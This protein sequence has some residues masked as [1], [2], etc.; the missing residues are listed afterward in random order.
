MSF[1]SDSSFH[2]WR[3]RVVAIALSLAGCAPPYDTLLVP[4]P[5]QGVGVEVKSQLALIVE[6]RVN[7]VTANILL[8]TGTILTSLASPRSVA[9][10][11]L[12]GDGPNPVDGSER[13]D[14]G[15]CRT[16][17]A[18]DFDSTL[19]V[20]ETVDI[21][22]VVI[23]R[24]AITVMH[25]TGFDTFAEA[26]VDFIMSAPALMQVD[27]R[28]EDHGRRLVLLPAGSRTRP[29]D[30]V[31]LSV[32]GPLIPFS[33]LKV[34]VIALRVRVGNGATSSEALL[35]TGGAVALALGDEVLTDAG[36]DAASLTQIRTNILGA[37]AACETSILR[38]PSVGIGSAVAD[39]LPAIL[40]PEGRRRA[41]LGW[42]FL[43]SHESVHVSTT[44]SWMELTQAA[45]TPTL[46]GEPIGTFGMALKSTTDGIYE[47]VTI[48]DGFGA[49]RAGLVVGEKIVRVNGIDVI[50]VEGKSEL[51]G[52]RVHR[53]G[54]AE[55]LIE[56]A[57]DVQRTVQVESDPIL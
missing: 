6:G 15:V 48:A 36:I 51:F 2:P 12:V 52:R 13:D 21:G 29:S 49:A 9:K 18:V 46:L 47:I 50:T 42:I 16:G 3:A 37:G 53:E 8:D 39:N 57:A 26:G 20:A 14:L 54:G 33:P 41:L 24:A 35:D 56:G 34:G 4:P 45:D 23:G 7:G 10:F 30:A 27:W 11:G 17:V 43:A 31:D 40:I 1:R 19:F 38:L 32:G 44:G 22:G 25:E 5:P 28:V 55:M